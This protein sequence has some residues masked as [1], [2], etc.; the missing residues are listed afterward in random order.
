MKITTFQSQDKVFESL[1]YQF[2][3]PKEYKQLSPDVIRT[4]LE[5]SPEMEQ[6]DELIDNKCYSLHKDERL[7]CFSKLFKEIIETNKELFSSKTTP[8]TANTLY[9]F[10]SD[11]ITLPIIYSEKLSSIIESFFQRLQSPYKNPEVKR[12]VTSETEKKLHERINYL[13]SDYVRLAMA[14]A[15]GV[16]IKEIPSPS[17]DYTSETQGLKKPVSMDIYRQ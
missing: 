1:G 14:T 13:H 4:L 9:K 12:A 16:S 7:V 10:H 15:L 5:V 17:Y 2:S 6:I 11:E 8:E 3:T